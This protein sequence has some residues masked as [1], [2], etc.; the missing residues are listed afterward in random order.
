MNFLKNFLMA[1]IGLFIISLL[2]GVCIILPAML[3][4]E[5]SSGWFSLLYLVTAPIFIAFFIALDDES[6]KEENKEAK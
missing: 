5:F 1:F 6:K 3:T 2:A 4:V